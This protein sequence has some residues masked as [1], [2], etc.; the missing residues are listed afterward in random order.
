MHACVKFVLIMHAR[1]ISRIFHEI[2]RHEMNISFELHALCTARWVTIGRPGGLY[3][4]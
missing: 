3:G 4:T 1:L 2:D